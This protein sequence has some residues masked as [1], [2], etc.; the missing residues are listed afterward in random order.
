MY[1][2]YNPCTLN[3]QTKKD[4]YPTL[5]VDYIL[6]KFFQISIVCLKYFD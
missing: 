2:K 3:I 6:T 1:Y 4:R 5:N